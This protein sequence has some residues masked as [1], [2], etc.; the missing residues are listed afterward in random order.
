MSCWA[1]GP[2]TT[3]PAPLQQPKPSKIATPA[4]RPPTHTRRT[5]PPLLGPTFFFSPRL[6]TKPTH[7]HGSTRTPASADPRGH[8]RRR[9]PANHHDRRHRAVRN[10]QRK[11][12]GLRLP[13]STGQH[14]D[15]ARE[16]LLPGDRLAP[17]HQMAGL[18][19]AAGPGW[20]QRLR[21]RAERPQAARQ[22]LAAKQ[23]IPLDGVGEAFLP[24]QVHRIPGPRAGDHPWH[25]QKGRERRQAL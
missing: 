12:R 19:P 20:L 25:T 23:Q 9:P 8:R 15:A 7:E 16:L 10:T 3:S 21:A 6:E 13:R 2:K 17:A 24:G 11:S 5:N 18:R 4:P 14:D 1:Q 22:N